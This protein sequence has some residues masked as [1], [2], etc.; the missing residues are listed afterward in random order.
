MTRNEN[1]IRQGMVA[2]TFKQLS[3]DQLAHAGDAKLGKVPGVLQG[4][5][6]IIGNP[7]VKS[8]IFGDG[9]VS[10]GEADLAQVGV[11]NVLYNFMHLGT[12]LQRPTGTGYAALRLEADTLELTRAYYFNRGTEVRAAG[13]VADIWSVP[14]SPLSASA[15]GSLRPL[16]DVQLPFLADVDQILGAIQSDAVTVQVT[17][18]VR[19][20]VVN[21][22]AFQQLGQGMRRFLLGDVKSETGG[23]AG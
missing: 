13:T 9:Y 11:V 2:L 3:L 17:G 6:T 16:K 23:S 1:D 4:R 22:I 18:T 12:D 19:K 5:F 14:D 8:R 15:V 10:I 7:E 20:A 21:P